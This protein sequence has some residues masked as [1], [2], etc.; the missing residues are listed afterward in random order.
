VTGGT[1][2]AST[3]IEGNLTAKLPS[4]TWDYLANKAK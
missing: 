2:I 4:T 1:P 3:S